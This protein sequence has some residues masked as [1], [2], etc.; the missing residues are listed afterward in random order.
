MLRRLSSLVLDTHKGSARWS[1]KWSTCCQYSVSG[2]GNGGPG[3]GD[4]GPTRDKKGK[5]IGNVRK[6]PKVHDQDNREALEFLENLDDIMKLK[7]QR[8]EREIEEARLLEERVREQ[9]YI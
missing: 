1:W 7:K 3:G 2:E 4:S 9:G 5:R 8:I 6:G